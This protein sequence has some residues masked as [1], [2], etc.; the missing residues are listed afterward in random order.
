MSA[1]KKIRRAPKRSVKHDCCVGEQTRSDKFAYLSGLFADTGLELLHRLI[2]SLGL[3]GLLLQSVLG[4]RLAQVADG[5]S[6][7]H[8]LSLLLVI[9]SRL[10]VGVQLLGCQNKGVM[11]RSGSRNNTASELIL[12]LLLEDLRR[13]VVLGIL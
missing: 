4:S 6:L 5:L 10:S 11:V 8:A 3:D 2:L 9:P 1:E 13:L 12:T 7:Q